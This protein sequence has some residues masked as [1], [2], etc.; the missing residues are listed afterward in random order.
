MSPT[1]IVGVFIPTPS[2]RSEGPGYLSLDLVIYDLSC[3]Y[4]DRP[5]RSNGHGSSRKKKRSHRNS[6]SESRT[7]NS[8]TSSQFSVG[9]LSDSDSLKDLQQEL[10]ALNFDDLEERSIENNEKVT[11]HTEKNECHS[12]LIIHRDGKIESQNHIS[13]GM[14]MCMH[15]LYYNAL[16]PISI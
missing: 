3:F 2:S 1:Q 8:S 10:E 13:A 6:Q 16:F 15:T 9:S 11:P 12:E 14:Y 5:S 4:T 7:R